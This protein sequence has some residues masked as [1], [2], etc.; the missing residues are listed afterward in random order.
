MCSLGSRTADGRQDGKGPDFSAR[1]LPIPTLA[2]HHFLFPQAACRDWK[3][4][5]AETG[6]FCTGKRGPGLS[7]SPSEPSGPWEGSPLP[8]TPALAP[9]GSHPQFGKCRGGG[10]RATGPRLSCFLAPQPA[11]R[12]T[13]LR[14]TGRWHPV[15]TGLGWGE[16]GSPRPGGAGGLKIAA[17]RF[18]LANVE[19][20]SW[21]RGGRSV[22]PSAEFPLGPR[23]ESRWRLM[24]CW[25]S[26]PKPQEG[27]GP[28]TGFFFY[29]RGSRAQGGCTLLFWAFR[30]IFGWGTELS[31]RGSN[32][33][34]EPAEGPWG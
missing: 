25:H 9:A 11:S 7:R 20:G 13:A 10:F 2:P 6:T 27:Q 1:E 31:L 28:G 23:S 14:M 24:R 12:G 4:W 22:C 29:L 30:A 26:T 5:W 21:R 17:A 18:Q 3:P 34:L 16:R 8:R 15:R 19:A 32:P 33:G